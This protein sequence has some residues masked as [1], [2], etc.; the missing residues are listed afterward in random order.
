[1][2]LPEVLNG[3]DQELVDQ[4]LGK[5]INPA[6]FENKEDCGGDA[7]NAFCYSMVRRGATRP[8]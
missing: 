6:S 1:M 7:A 2:A 4:V 3:R 8:I 5:D